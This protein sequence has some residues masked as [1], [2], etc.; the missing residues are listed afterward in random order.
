MHRGLV[1]LSA[2]V[3]GAGQVYL[4]LGVVVPNAVLALVRYTRRQGDS[5]LLSARTAS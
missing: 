4:L 3:L 2:S 1:A 5:L